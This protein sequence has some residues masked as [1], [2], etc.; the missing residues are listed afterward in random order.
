MRST[1]PA[2]LW[3]F[4]ARFFG[5]NNLIEG[6]LGEGDG[7]HRRIEERPIG[8]L[9]CA[10]D[11]QPDIAAAPAGSRAFA[12][13]QA[14]IAQAT[15]GERRR[16]R[17]EQGGRPRHGGH[18]RRGDG[19]WPRSPWREPRVRCGP[20]WSGEPVGG[21]GHAR[22]GAFPGLA[23]G[24]MPPGAGVSG[25]SAW[26]NLWHE[27]SGGQSPRRGPGH[28]ERGTPSLAREP[29][30]RL[31]PPARL[32][33]PAGDL[34]PDLQLLPRRRRHHRSISRPWPTRSAS[35]PTRCSCRC[36]CAP[37]AL[38]SRSR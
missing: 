23:G 20:G 36:S 8:S 28:R 29:G 12:V 32:H 9:L 26:A 10:A 7:Q 25:V 16:L 21:G 37:P 14:G 6:R 4:V 22:R 15:A 35:S 2:A 5:D 38:R 34:V 24:R 1:L 30:A 17:R 3:E 27:R 13:F 11:G 19:R 33:R 18:L 31:G